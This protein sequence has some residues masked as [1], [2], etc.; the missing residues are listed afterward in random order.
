MHSY[1]I[2]TDRRFLEGSI[3]IHPKDKSS[4]IQS[5]KK[6]GNKD[7][8]TFAKTLRE[9]KEDLWKVRRGWIKVHIAV[10]VKTKEVVSVEITD[11][12]IGDGKMLLHW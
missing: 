3:K 6:K 10:D 12:S 7:R 2:Q 1:K 8:N 4:L 11:E 9:S 5:N